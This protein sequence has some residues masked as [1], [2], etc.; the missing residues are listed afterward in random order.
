MARG[1]KSEGTSKY[2]YFKQLFAKHPE[3]L[4]GKQNDAILD[5]YLADHCIADGVELDKNV[6]SSMANLKSISRKKQRGKPAASATTAAATSASATA[7]PKVRAGSKLEHLEE[8]I[9]DCLSMAKNHDRDGLKDVLH[10]L[11][12]A[13]NEVVWKLGQPS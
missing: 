10:L 7:A 13:R 8:M 12:R 9:D 1:S 3:L 2:A 11:R 6:K 4:N 5:H